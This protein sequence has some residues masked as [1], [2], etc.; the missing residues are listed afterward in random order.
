MV[1]SLENALH[2]GAQ[3]RFEGEATSLQ[4]GMALPPSSYYCVLDEQPD[5]LVPSSALEQPKS[6]SG[7]LV[8]NPDLWFADRNDIY[9]EI[10]QEIGTL[11]NMVRGPNIVWVRQAAGG[12]LLP[13]WLGPGLNE[14]VAGLVPGEPIGPTFPKNTLGALTAAEILINS[15]DAAARRR[16][17]TATLAHSALQFQDRGF[18]PIAGLLHPYHISALR[19]YYRYQIRTRQLKLGDDQSPKRYVAHNEIVTSFFHRQLTDTVAVLAG[20]SVKPSYVYVVSYQE[21]SDLE[22]HIDREQCEF[23]VTL[24]LDYSPE[25]EMETPWPLHLETC[26]TDVT[27][28]QAIGDALAY[29]GREINHFRSPLAKGNTSTSLLFHYV[30]SSYTGSLD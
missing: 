23:S 13:F 8:R 4:F 14:L 1:S 29:R 24:C 3:H 26:D 7:T 2:S 27:V 15:E 5:H 9:S 20:E 12:T 17:W 19:R 21:G 11:Q 28:F 18:V 30:R 25:P 22:K 10:G 16:S 6:P